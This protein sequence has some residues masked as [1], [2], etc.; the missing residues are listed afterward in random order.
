MNKVLFRLYDL[1]FVVDKGGNVVLFWC[2]YVNLRVF[3]VPC[4]CFLFL[5]YLCPLS[6]RS[7]RFVCS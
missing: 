3:Q 5:V 7:C 6:F 2:I 4:F 1:F